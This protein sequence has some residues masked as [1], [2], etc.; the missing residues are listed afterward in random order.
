M[1]CDFRA[2]VNGVGHATILGRRQTQVNVA[3]YRSAFFG[4]LGR[5]IA[6]AHL[7][8]EVDLIVLIYLATVCHV[9]ASGSTP[10][11]MPWAESP[12]RQ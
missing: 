3:F 7:G 1:L 11:A 6:L 8:Q 9:L 2:M 10:R 12:R 4:H 5:Q